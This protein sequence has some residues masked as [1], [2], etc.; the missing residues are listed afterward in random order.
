MFEFGAASASEVLNPLLKS[1]MLKFVAHASAPSSNFLSLRR[2]DIKD[3]E[4]SKQYV[5]I[6]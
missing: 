4:M 5:S 2:N 1:K 3:L 6:E